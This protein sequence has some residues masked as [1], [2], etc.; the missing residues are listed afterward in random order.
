M[1]IHDTMDEQVIVESLAN[2]FHKNNYADLSITEEN[3]Q[4]FQQFKL[5]A[6]KYYPCE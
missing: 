4:A 5:Y 2:L 6:E 1:N 3:L